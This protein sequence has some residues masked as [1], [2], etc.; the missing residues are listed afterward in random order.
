MWAYL[1]TSIT[2]G[3][4]A[5][6]TAAKTAQSFGLVCKELVQIGNGC[7]IRFGTP[8]LAPAV[9]YASSTVR[10]PYFKLL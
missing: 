7:C 1:A 9:A 4:S 8:D 3:L 6:S 10:V 2:T 5:A